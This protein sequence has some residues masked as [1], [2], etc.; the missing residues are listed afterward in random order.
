MMK[1]SFLCALLALTLILPAVS[2]GETVQAGVNLSDYFSKRDLSG[3]WDGKSAV[4]MTLT[5][6]VTITEAGVYI[7]S[8]TIENGTVT[9]SAGKDDKVQL[10]LN[11]VS[12]ACASSAAILVENAD[13]VFI[14]LPE[15]TE[16]RLVSTGFDENSSVDAAVFARD[17]V[18]FNGKGTL[19]IESAKHG[20]VGKNDVK[21]TGGT[22]TITAQNRGIYADDSVCVADGSVTI[23]SGKEAIVAKNE[24]EAEKG[25]IL[26]G[27]G[28]LNLTA[29]GGADNGKT[30]IDDM[31]MGRGGWNNTASASSQDDDSGK[32]LKATGRVMLAGGTVVI[33]AAD[34]AV[35]SDTKVVIYDGASLTVSSGDDAIHSDDVLT[36]E[37][38]TIRILKSY[39][40][41]EAVA[42][43]I[44]G[45]DIS[46]TASDDG[47]NSAGGNDGSGWG[48]NDMF[49]NDGSSI[50]INGGS[51]YVNAAGDGIDANGDVTVNGGTVVVS[52]PTNSMNGALDANGSLTVN[53]GTVIA[54]GAVGMAETF[55]SASTQVSFLTNLSGGE[56]SQITVTDESGQVILSAAVEKSFSCVVVSSP[57][58]KVGET[59][60]VSSGTSSVTVTVSATSSGGS[61][62][63]GGG[64]GGGFGPS[65]GGPGGGSNQRPGQNK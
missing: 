58:L 15:G 47:M 9:V 18:I 38:G 63:F 10:V 37:G 31:F 28:A 39:E 16:N 30:H 7:L 12:I 52:G 14:T 20:V 33:D 50:T 55:G 65:G 45:G 29:G 62:D 22:Y 1:K 43:T 57:E 5:E 42:I 21:I 49:A 2:L 6:S 36:I 61:G 51:V 32:G 19:A 24:K 11:N 26:V 8:G 59:Y 64:Q 46:L 48:R 17:D 4:E 53:G 34:D 13:K 44:N 35:H 56:N 3:E 25:F 54:A 41:L 40:G 23:V 60:T 27:G